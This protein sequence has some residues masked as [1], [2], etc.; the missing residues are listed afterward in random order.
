[1]LDTVTRDYVL[2]EANGGVPRHV[3]KVSDLPLE[4]SFTNPDG[5]EA[6]ISKIHV[7]FSAATAGAKLQWGIVP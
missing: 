2:N 6:T 5:T 3:L 1:M 4:T 7:L